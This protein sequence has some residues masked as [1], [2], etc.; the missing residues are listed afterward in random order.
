MTK[1]FLVAAIISLASAVAA[2]W[3]H[4]QYDPV[5][6][7]VKEWL[8]QERISRSVATDLYRDQQR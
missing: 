1:T 4:M 3:Y 7:A 5:A 2:Y 6:E 8:S